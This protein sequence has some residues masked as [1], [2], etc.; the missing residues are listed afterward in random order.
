MKKQFRKNSPEGE[1]IVFG[2]H[3][4]TEA[5]EMGKGSTLCINSEARKEIISTAKRMGIKVEN[6]TTGELNLLCNG[7]NHQGVVLFVEGYKYQNW[8]ELIGLMESQQSGNRVIMVLDRI[9]D[10]RNLGAVL[11]SAF[12]NDVEATLIPFSESAKV[13]SGTIKTSAGAALHT[14]VARANNLGKSLGQLRELGFKVVGLSMDGSKPIYEADLTGDIVIVTGSEDKGIRPS[15]EAQCDEML[16]I[17]MSSSSIGSFNASVSASIAL[18][19]VRRQQMI[20][21]K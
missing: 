17:P 3:V 14:K 6:M 11:R 4:V 2:V 9:T 21:K 1:H 8:S 7:G 12:L 5:L 18:Y 13:T 16:T 20:H 10:P 15:L 19:E